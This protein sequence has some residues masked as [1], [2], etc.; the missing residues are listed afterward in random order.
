ML[1]ICI[2]QPADHALVLRVVLPGL[3]LE[4][5]DAAL[6]QRDRDLYPLIPENQV[7]RARKKVRND[8]EISEGFVGVADF[9]AHK[10]AFLCASIQL[11]RFGLHRCGR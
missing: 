2:E 10:F 1:S 11:Q 6:A 5:R 9:L 7:L 4:E 3:V 8:L